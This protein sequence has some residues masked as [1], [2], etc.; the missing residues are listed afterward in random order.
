M[1]Y[2][3]AVIRQSHPGNSEIHMKM[4]PVAATAV[5]SAIQLRNTEQSLSSFVR[6]TSRQIHDKN[7]NGA[8]KKTL[9]T[10]IGEGYTDS[11]CDPNLSAVMSM[12]VNLRNENLQATKIIE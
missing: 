11:M 3:E 2:Y 7:I 1:A 12:F 6:T 10:T 4:Q 5:D 8:T 9:Y